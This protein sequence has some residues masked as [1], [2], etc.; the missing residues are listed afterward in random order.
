MNKN[1]KQYWDIRFYFN[2]QRLKQ[3]CNNPN[4]IEY[5]YYGGRGIKVEWK[6]FGE[7]REDMYGSYLVHKQINKTTSLDRIKTNGNYCKENCRWATMK[8]Q[9]RNTRKNIYIEFNG[10]KKLLLDWSKETGILYSTLRARIFD[11]KWPIEK[12]FKQEIK[13]SNTHQKRLLKKK[14]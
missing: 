11:Y 14:N 4:T 9:C 12:A 10:K 5:K 8:E 7:F 3:R 13:N 6:S 2:F 1:L